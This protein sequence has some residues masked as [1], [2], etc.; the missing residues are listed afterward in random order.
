ML[1]G[2]FEIETLTSIADIGLDKV[3]GVGALGD[4]RG[5]R[6]PN[7]QAGPFNVDQLDHTEARPAFDS[8]Q[9]LEF[10]AVPGVFARLVERCEDEA[11]SRTD[12]GRDAVL[13][14][15]LAH[16]EPDIRMQRVLARRPPDRD[17]IRSNLAN[18]PCKPRK[19]SGQGRGRDG[20]WTA[21]GAPELISAA[22]TLAGRGLESRPALDRNRCLAGA[23]N[24]LLA[25]RRG[26]A[27]ETIADEWVEAVGLGVMPAFGAA[28]VEPDIGVE[29][30]EPFLPA[31]LDHVPR[32]S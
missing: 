16:R 26:L 14:Q 15:R 4:R 13:V 1:V 18:P 28:P 19:P 5:H 30:A 3:E 20:V 17:R 7:R 11:P 9:L 2:H 10:V 8:N 27:I 6:A 23:L 21:Q 24:F 25:A 32:I 31:A 29:S 22:G 12:V